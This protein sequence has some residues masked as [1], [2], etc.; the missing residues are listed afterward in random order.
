MGDERTGLLDD[1][2]FIS[3]WL[4]EEGGWEVLDIGASVASMGQA[5]AQTCQPASAIHEQRQTNTHSLDQ[6][7]QKLQDSV[8]ACTS[9]FEN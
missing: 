4:R 8:P 2:P 5:R 7:E 1:A 3:G 9:D 6:A